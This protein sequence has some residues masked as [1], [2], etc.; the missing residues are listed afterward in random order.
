MACTLGG[1]LP[2]LFKLS[3]FSGF[4]INEFE[5][6]QVSSSAF[7]SLRDM[8]SRHVF[9]VL[10]VTLPAGLPCYWDPVVVSLYNVTCGDVST[11]WNSKPCFLNNAHVITISHTGVGCVD[12]VCIVLRIPNM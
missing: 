2:S 3:Y 5:L 4:C 11:R 8:Q 6:S 9:M 1:S 7:H 10:A 12:K